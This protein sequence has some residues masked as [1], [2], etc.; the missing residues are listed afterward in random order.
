MNFSYDFGFIR[1]VGGFFLGV[2]ACDIYNAVRK[3]SLVSSSSAG[4]LWLQIISVAGFIGGIWA[5]EQVVSDFLM[6]A[7]IFMIILSF[8]IGHKTSLSALLCIAPLRWLGAI[9]YSIYMS[10]EAVLWCYNQILRVIFGIPDLEGWYRDD[11]AILHTPSLLGGVFLVVAVATVLFVSHWTYR[12][13]E[14]P[15]RLWSRRFV[16]KRRV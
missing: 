3:H 10:H 1:C 9:S 12:L 15:W 14:E 13:V 5:E 4:L 16:S 11:Q 7:P 8:A 6:I 2:V